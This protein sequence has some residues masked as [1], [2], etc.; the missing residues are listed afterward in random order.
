MTREVEREFFHLAGVYLACRLRLMGGKVEHPN[1]P[2]DTGDVGFELLG[3]CDHAQ[4]MKMLIASERERGMSQ[5]VATDEKS[6]NK[7]GEHDDM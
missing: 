1:L 2:R 6:A 7:K 3:M 5:P 4:E